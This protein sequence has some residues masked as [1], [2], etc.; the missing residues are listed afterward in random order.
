MIKR[1][2]TSVAICLF[3]CCA[4]AQGKRAENSTNH[5]MAGFTM[6]VSIQNKSRIKINGETRAIVQ[7]GDTLKIY[8]APGHKTPDTVMV[9]NH[10][11]KGN[12]LLYPANKTDYKEYCTIDIDSAGLSPQSSREKQHIMDSM[13]AS[14]IL[15]LDNDMVF[16]KGGTFLMGISDTTDIE[17]GEDQRPQHK[18]F[19]NSFYISKYEV[20]QALWMA[21]MDTNPSVHKDCYLCPVDHISWNE[22]QLFIS[23]LNKMTTHHYRLPTEAEWEYA[24]KGG[25]MSKGYIYSGSNDINEVAW[26]YTI[27]GSHRTGTKKPNELGLYDMSGNIIEWCSDWYGPYTKND[28]RNP[29]GPAQGTLKVIRGG[30][31]IGHD[32]ACLNTTR[33]GSPV[34][35]GDQFMGFRLVRDDK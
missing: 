30:D 35:V 9:Y 13:S 11:K 26:Y 6:R 31:W 2:L 29:K 25:I 28:A 10:N 5:T 19:L 4:M 16:V 14:S 21:V 12:T 33:G 18:V 20:T 3:S 17:G 8:F 32:Q 22:A 24:A 27:T 34:N 7:Q 1:V 15:N 23:K